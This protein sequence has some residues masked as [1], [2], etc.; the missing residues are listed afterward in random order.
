MLRRQ[1]GAE[2]RRIRDRAQRTVADVAG[3]LDWSESKL[4]RIETANTGIRA[5]DLD[6]LLRLYGVDDA[7]HSRLRAMAAQSRQRA[8]WEAYGGALADA[9]E[10]FIGFE[11]EAT[12]I[13]AYEAQVVP[14]LLQTAEYASAVTRASFPPDQLDVVEQRV[15]VRMARQAVLT[16]Q[17]PPRLWT[18]LDEAV[19]RRQVGGPDVLRR[20]LLR[21]NE[22]SERKVVTIQVLPFAAG[23]HPAL[24][25]SFMV[26]EFSGAAERPLVYSEGAT[27][28]VFRNRPEDLRSY[29]S[30]FEALGAAALTP[31]ES[32]EFIGAVAR[33]ER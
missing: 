18:I 33:G 19:L 13:R 4:S 28:G 8:W 10:T 3:Q 32:I 15:A 21:L 25:G 16:R 11:T 9:Y 2:L 12:S 24:A 31:M 30:S 27:G 20:Q 7:E 6:R 17:P 5:A 22:A 1:L 29:E 14:G 23:A 26:L